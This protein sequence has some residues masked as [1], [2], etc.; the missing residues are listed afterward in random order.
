MISKEI[1]QKVKHI[2]IRT[3]KLVNA[4]L[5]G[6]YHSV[7]KGQGMEFDE[8]RAYQYGDD[9]RSIDWNVSARQGHLYVKRYVEERELTVML[10]VDLS[11]SKDFGTLRRM[12]NELAAEIAALLAFSAIQNNDRVGALIFTD[13]VEKY[14]P[15]KKGKKHVLRV[16]RELLAYEPVHRKTSIETAVRYLNNVLTK[17]SVVFLISDFF[18]QG[19][20]KSLRVA[21][22][23][24]DLVALPIS[25][26]REAELP[27]VGLI[28]MLDP[29]SGETFWVDTSL[30][31][32]R[33]R[34]RKLASDSVD[35]RNRI[36]RRNRIEFVDISTHKPYD[37]PLVRFFRERAKRLR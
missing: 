36:F 9:M 33:E 7:F 20:E 13:I 6:E 23:R 28:E 30:R 10:M 12:K 15:P 21:N 27:N 5:G 4:A 26:P 25:D 22:Q 2:E 14:I 34:Y 24:H 37:V 8:V 11:G 17:K 35:A 19:Y 1:L 16:V 32:V 31:Q 3:S 18:D 29:E